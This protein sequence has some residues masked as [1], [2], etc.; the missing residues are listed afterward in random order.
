L[1]GWKKAFKPWFSYFYCMEAEII[2][3]GYCLCWQSGNT[4]FY[5]S[6]SRHIMANF[7]R[8]HPDV[9]RDRIKRG[10]GYKRRQWAAYQQGRSY[11]PRLPWPEEL[12]AAE[13]IDEVLRGAVRKKEGYY[14]LFD[15]EPYRAVSSLTLRGNLLTATVKSKMAPTRTSSTF[16]ETEIKNIFLGSDGDFDLIDMKCQCK[17]HLWGGRVKGGRYQTVFECMHLAAMEQEFFERIYAPS[18]YK[19]PLVVKGRESKRPL[20]SPFRFASN[21]LRR[22]NGLVPVSPDLAALEEDVKVAYYILGMDFFDIDRILLSGDVLAAVVSPTTLEEFK[23][24]KIA[25]EVLRQKSGQETGGIKAK[26]YKALAEQMDMFLHANGYRHN[27]RF[28]ELGRPAER[29]ET[30]K[31]VVGVVFSSDIPP[32]YTVREKTTGEKKMFETDRGDA[33]PFSQTGRQQKRLDDRTKVE[34]PFRVGLPPRIGLPG[35][36]PVTIGLPKD[37]RDFLEKEYKKH[38]S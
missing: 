23:E 8:T 1:K 30:D 4:K 6:P 15:V 32:F 14:T 26:A 29:Y 10:Q 22:G 19:N 28:L 27:G 37:A 35:R 18:P 34:T 16:Y 38:L 17:D 36:G 12:L 21:W 31:H 20:F 7:L 13:K 9:L 11:N 2:P 5:F 24:G 3:R 25:F 33:N